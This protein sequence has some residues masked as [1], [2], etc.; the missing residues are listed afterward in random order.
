MAALLEQLLF[1]LPDGRTGEI[2]IDGAVVR[3]RL[4]GV[5]RDDDLRRYIL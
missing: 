3:E 5:V 4:A 2:R 1:D